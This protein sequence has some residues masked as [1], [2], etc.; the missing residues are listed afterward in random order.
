MPA[1]EAV[2]AIDR[3]VASR[4]ERD[5]RDAA[6]LAARR[7]EHLALA[8][9]HTASAAAV[10]GTSGFTRCA[11]IRAAAGLV[12]EALHCEKL[13]FA[14]SEWE[15]LSAIH[16]SEHFVCIHVASESPRYL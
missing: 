7:F 15:L 1:S 3:F 12:G 16:A 5:F 8:S 13:L 6:A 10:R 4:L 9:A 14:R 11:A 2:A